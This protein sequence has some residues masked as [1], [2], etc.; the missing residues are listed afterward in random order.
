MG[1]DV[2][3]LCSSILD[4]EMLTA[5]VNFP[6]SKGGDFIS[7]GAECDCFG[8]ADTED[9]VEIEDGSDTEDCAIAFDTPAA[10]AK[11]AALAGA[12]LTGATLGATGG[13]D[14]G[15]GPLD[16]FLGWNVLPK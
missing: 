1:L 3:R 14:V 6:E 10:A 13:S 7:L 9:C 5:L 12:I 8:C 16:I 15:L 4:D 11:A 2:F